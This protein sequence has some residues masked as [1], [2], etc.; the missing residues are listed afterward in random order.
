MSHDKLF[1]PVKLFDP[2]L[3][4]LEIPGM[5]KEITIDL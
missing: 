1:L 2:G 4:L 3:K 5:A